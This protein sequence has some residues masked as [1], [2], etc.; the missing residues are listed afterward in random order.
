MLQVI[1]RL[2]GV[3]WREQGPAFL[4]GF[5]H[6]GTHWIAAF[7]YL[8][9]PYITRDLGFSY[10]DSGLLVAVFHLSA[11]LANFGSGDV[12]VYRVRIG[13]D[14][15]GVPEPTTA[16]LLAAG[17]LLMLMSARIATRPGRF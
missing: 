7:F 5:G 8:L 17:L 11:L 9:L 4:V 16:L 1:S 14:N 3:H 6:G 13:E 12:E 15:V 10:T 2:T